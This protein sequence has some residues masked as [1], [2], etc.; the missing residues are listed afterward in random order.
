LPDGSCRLADVSGIGKSSV[1][2]T[3]STDPAKDSFKWKWNK[4]V[5]TPSLGDPLSPTISYA[6]CIYDG[7]VNPQPLLAAEIP[8]GSVVPTCGTKPCWSSAGTGYKYKNK[9][10]TPAGIT[11]VKLN[12]GDAGK[13]QVQV[14][15]KGALLAPPA[16]GALSTPVIV[17]LLINDGITTECFKTTFSSGDQTATSFKAKGP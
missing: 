10:A 7:S 15:G 5:A 12:A 13:A 8:N 9:A 4:G 6:L 1:Q 14:K 17:Q 3:N 2:I 11:D 16:L